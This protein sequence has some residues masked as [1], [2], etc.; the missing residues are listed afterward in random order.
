[1]AGLAVTVARLDVLGRIDQVAVVVVEIG[2]VTGQGVVPETV[3]VVVGFGIDRAVETG[4]GVGQV[5]IADLALHRQRRLGEVV[6]RLLGIEMRDRQI[7]DA[8]VETGT[9]VSA[10]VLGDDARRDRPVLVEVD[11]QRRTHAVGVRIVVILFDAIAVVD[12]DARGRER[13]A[14]EHIIDVT[15][16]VFLPADEA[17]GDLVVDRQVEEAFGDMADAAAVDAVGLDAVTARARAGVRLAGDDAHRAGLRTGAVQRALRAG[18]R[19]KPL[20]VVHVDVERTLDRGDRLLVE[21]HAHARLRAGVVAVAAAGDAA[22]VDLHETRAGEHAAAGGA[23]GQAGDHL[24]VVVEIGDVLL[25]QLGVADGLDADRHLL[26]VFLALL[27]GHRHGTDGG[28]LV[29]LGGGL[30]LGRAAGVLLGLRLVGES[31]RADGETDRQR[32]RQLGGTLPPGDSVSG[33]V[34]RLTPRLWFGSNAWMGKNFRHRRIGIEHGPQR[35]FQR[36]QP[37][38]VM[39]PLVHAIAI[40]RAPYLF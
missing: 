36:A 30:V 28:G 26:Q 9:A 32:E 6:V 23:V 35:E 21:V 37:R 18:Q 5:E 29:L 12:G 3:V 19:F 7:A 4:E 11:A 38:L 40:D 27:R 25:L 24:R 13:P 8:G 14:S 20:D 34:H 22:H 39:P 2:A 33:M 31:R 1:M 17:N 10:H 16:F 15:R